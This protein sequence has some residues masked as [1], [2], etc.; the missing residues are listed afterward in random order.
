M[1][2]LD[3]N[4]INRPVLE[5]TMMD[6]AKTIITVTSP[7]EGLVEE[8]E[9]TLPEL[10]KVLAASDQGALDA[11]YDLA[12]RVMSCNKQGLTVTVEDLRGKFWPK[13]RMRN[14][15]NLVFFFGAYMEFISEINSA[16]N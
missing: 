2:R 14:L 11:A 7:T 16:K 15:E 12:A 13:D 10:Q 3:F 8:L 5:L 6:E 9:A 1:A 4:S